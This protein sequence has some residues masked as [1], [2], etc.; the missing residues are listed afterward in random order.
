MAG[1]TFSGDFPTTAGAY[2]TLNNGGSDA[3]VS[4]LNNDLTSLLA[5]TYLGGGADDY[6]GSVIIDSAEN[7]YVYT[8][9]YS[10]NFPTSAGAYDTSHNG[11][12][13]S[14]V[15]KLDG[16]LTNIL[17]STY[18]GGAAAD[19]VSIMSMDASGNIYVIGQTNSINFPTTPEAYDIS[20]NGGND[21]FV[22]KL[23][24]NLTNLLASTYLGG[25]GAEFRLLY[26][27]KFR[28]KYIC[29]WMD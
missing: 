10:S 1:A 14:T 15:S 7:V 20:L 27:Y 18:I 6:G 19:R 24:G 3:F 26:S 9:T 25:S 28:W 29:D 23:N 21:A 5:S 22:S 8:L 11:S 16:N 2:N 17:A 13:D 12:L 4:K